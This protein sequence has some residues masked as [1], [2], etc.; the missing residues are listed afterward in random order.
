V[1]LESGVRSS[2]IVVVIVGHRY[3]TLVPGLEIS[4]SEAEY[5]EAFRLNLECLIYFSAAS[6]YPDEEDVQKALLLQ[7]WKRTLSDRH[8]PAYF[9]DANKLALQVAIDVGRTIRELE[10]KDNSSDRV[11]GTRPLFHSPRRATGWTPSHACLLPEV[12]RRISTTCSR[13]N[14]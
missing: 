14:N 9:P 2:R 4:F 3:G 8:T 10:D 11:Q 13:P 1:K 5:Q 12:W 7:Q 6:E